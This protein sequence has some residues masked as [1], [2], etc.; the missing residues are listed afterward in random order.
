MTWLPGTG[1]FAA[2]QLRVTRFA[3]N[4]YGP[5]FNHERVEGWEGTISWL[6]GPPGSQEGV[7]VVE[8]LGEV[9]VLCGVTSADPPIQEQLRNLQSTG[10]VVRIRGELRSRVHPVLE[11]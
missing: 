3:S 6:P 7:H 2:C 1:R 10:T 5:A 11:P 8:L 4:D 9:P